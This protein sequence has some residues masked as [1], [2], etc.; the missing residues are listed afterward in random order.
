VAGL[1]GKGGKEIPWPRRRRG[2]GVGGVVVRASVTRGGKRGGGGGGDAMRRPMEGRGEMEQR[3]HEGRPW[4]GRSMGVFSGTN[5]N[6][7]L[8]ATILF[9]KNSFGKSFIRHGK[10][11]SM[12]FG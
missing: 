9:K 10:S 8:H 1:E 4:G 3:E 12:F 5:L 6:D 2:R 11:Y 7:I